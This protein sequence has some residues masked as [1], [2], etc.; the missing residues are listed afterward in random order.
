MQ[1]E[2]IRGFEAGQWY[3]QTCFKV[4]ITATLWK[5]GCRGYE[6]EQADP[7]KGVVIAFV[8]HNTINF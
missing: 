5:I 6:Q 1:R 8:R 2:V 3:D 4:I 7:Q